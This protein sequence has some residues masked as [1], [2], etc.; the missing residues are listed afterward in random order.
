MDMVTVMDSGAE[1]VIRIVWLTEIFDVD[2]CI[3]RTTIYGKSTKV[4]I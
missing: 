3:T 4:F 1:V 2:H